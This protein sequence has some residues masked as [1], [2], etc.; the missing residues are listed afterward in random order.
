MRLSPHRGE[1]DPPH[2]PCC[3]SFPIPSSIKLLA[4]F[5]TSSAASSRHHTAPTA[6]PP[7]LSSTQL[8]TCITPEE[9]GS[10]ALQAKI[11]DPETGE[12]VPLN[13]PGELQ[14][15]GYCVM[16]GYWE[17]PTKTNEVITDD[18]WYKTG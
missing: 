5:L 4:P 9:P 18:K 2:L 11:E 10:L 15:R 16:L 14:V 8:G 12:I 1:H 17:D 13:T 6:F 7:S 3:F